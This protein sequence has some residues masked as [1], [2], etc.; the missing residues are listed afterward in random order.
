MAANQILESVNIGRTK[1]L[2]FAGD[3]VRLAGQI[4]YP[5]VPTGKQT[6]PLIFLLHHAGCVSRSGYE[7][8]AQLGVEAGYAV[9]RW[10]KR[11]TGCSGAGG[12]GSTT[13]DA[14]DAY[15]YALDQP[16]VDHRK[17]VII[18]QGAGTGLL[19]SAYGLFARIQQPYG[20]VLVANMLDE[21]AVQAIDSRVQI[22]VGQNDWNPWR[23]FGQAA[24]EAHL[25]AYRHGASFYVAPEAD[26]M[27]VDPR[28]ET[29][30]AGAKR[31]IR[32]WLESI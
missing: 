23:R 19:G 13:Q 28:T 3:G 20:V 26:R 24:C 21:T 1:E 17:M 11:G 5:T 6:F 9:F 16:G 2:V 22:V 30:H 12:R 29:F 14:V 32:E 25:A 27:L 18:A 10:D 8:Y 15:E 31:A 7:H 4:D